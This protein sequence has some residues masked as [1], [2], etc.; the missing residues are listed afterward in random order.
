MVGQRV[1]CLLRRLLQPCL[2]ISLGALASLMEI[3]HGVR[4]M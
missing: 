1:L 4:D 2:F 3:E